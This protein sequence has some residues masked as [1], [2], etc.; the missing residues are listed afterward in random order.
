MTTPQ[1][2][3]AELIAAFQAQWPMQ[4]EMT[5]LRLQNQKLL[6]SQPKLFDEDSDD[7]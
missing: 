4:F 3:A 2:E 7:E 6:D 5:V 1:I